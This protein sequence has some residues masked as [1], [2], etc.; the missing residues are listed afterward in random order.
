MGNRGRDEQNR[1]RAG[2]VKTA[3]QSKYC[4]RVRHEAQKSISLD[5]RVEEAWEQAPCLSTDFPG[6]P[7]RGPPGETAPMTTGPA[8]T[9]VAFRRWRR[10]RSNMRLES[11]MNIART[12]DLY[13]GW[14]H[15]QSTR[16]C[17][18]HPR[19]HNRSRCLTVYTSPSSMR[20]RWGGG[21]GAAATKGLSCQ[22]SWSKVIWVSPLQDC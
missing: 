6:S 17:S 19:R 8:R 15:S 3:N 20:A 21:D 4:W 2:E 5:C 10:L 11:M 12:Q 14:Y 22:S 18:L 13:S 7:P 1:L 9:S 16:Y